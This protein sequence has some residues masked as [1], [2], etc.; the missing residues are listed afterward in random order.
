MT[1]PDFPEKGFLGDEIREWARQNRQRY[2][3]LF[4]IADRIN[5]FAYR[6]VQ[7]F[8]TD[9]RNNQDTV[10]A[11]LFFVAHRNYQ[12]AV[13]LCRMGL[14]GEA[15]VMLRPLV[16]AC[17]LHRNSYREPDFVKAYVCADETRKLKLINVAH[18][19]PSDSLKSLREDDE[20][21]GLAEKL[22]KDIEKF[23][24]ED[25][26]NIGNLECLAQRVDLE[27]IYNTAYRQLCNYTHHGVRTL[28]D[29]FLVLDK[30]EQLVGYNLLPRDDTIHQAMYTA[31]DIFLIVLQDASDYFGLEKKKDIQALGQELYDL[32]ERQKSG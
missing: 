13:I 9:P 14:L 1:K 22:R 16:E 24:L 18:R 8:R 31:T 26:P 2:E 3:E 4:A 5:E 28:Q 19:S 7:E 12:A 6:I 10:T 17:I 30:K 23:G 21:H 27:G 11:C 15:Y 32:A 25:L 20:A 29:E